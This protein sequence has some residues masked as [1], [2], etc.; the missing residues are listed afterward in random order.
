MT[1]SETTKQARVFNASDIENMPQRTRANF[2]N[3][4]SGFKSANLVGTR[5][6][7]SVDNLAVVSSVFHVGAHPPLLGMIMRPHTV[8]RDTL[9]NIKDTGVYTINHICTDIVGPSHQTSAR[10]P[11]EES[12]FVHTGLTPI[13]STA[14]NAPYV[15]ESNIS[16]AM[17]VQDIQL[18]AINKTELV[19][20]QIVEVVMKNNYVNDD[21][22]VDIERANSVAISGLDAYHKTQSIDR[23][24]YAKPGKAIKSIKL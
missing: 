1:Q 6:V 7:N 14:V 4:L 9:Q 8:V 21:G 17:Q 23:F 24:A 5:N 22:Y 16:L 3:A 18:I 15:I 20:G 19:I 11:S 10:Y 2:I 12:E 13:D